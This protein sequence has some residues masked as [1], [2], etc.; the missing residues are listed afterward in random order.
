MVPGSLPSWCRE[1]R[2]TFCTADGSSQGNRAPVFA[3]TGAGRGQ[4]RIAVH[5]HLAG[6]SLVRGAAYFFL[7]QS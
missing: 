7:W 2:G 1:G 3:E 5:S 4:P 6:V